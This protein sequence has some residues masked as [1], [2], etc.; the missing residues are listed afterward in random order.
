VEPAIGQKKAFRVTAPRIRIRRILSLPQ[1][2]SYHR[3][4][5]ASVSLQLDA[6]LRKAADLAANLD[7]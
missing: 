7:M 3:E 4:A 2:F 1:L 6:E 5:H